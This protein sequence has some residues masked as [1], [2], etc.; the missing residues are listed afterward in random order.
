[1]RIQLTQVGKRYGENRL[2]KGIDILIPDGGSLAILGPNGSGKSTLLQMIFGYV[3]VT[4]GIISRTIETNEISEDVLPSYISFASPYMELPE[5]LTMQ[6]VISLHFTFKSPLSNT[7]VTES[8]EALGL[9]NEYHKQIK[10]FSSGMKQRLK[11]ILALTSRSNVL[12][13]DEPCSNLDE[14]GIKWYSNNIAMFMEN[15]T[16]IIASNL[17]YEY[18]QCKQQINV[19]DGNKITG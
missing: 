9:A 8:V 3:S 4:E 5:L 14:S 13:L 6:E 2:F 11:L 7:I 12:L 10:K 18:S 16:T 15:R 17:L 1:M 19:S